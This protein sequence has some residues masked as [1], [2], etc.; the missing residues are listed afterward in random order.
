MQHQTV[1]Q[2]V[3]HEEV[4]QVDGLWLL[5]QRKSTTCGQLFKSKRIPASLMSSFDRLVESAARALGVAIDEGDDS[6]SRLIS[7]AYDGMPRDKFY[8]PRTPSIR[9]SKAP[10]M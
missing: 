6:T 5:V 9:Q 4:V 3:T 8:G 7:R 10:P 1:E 2:Q